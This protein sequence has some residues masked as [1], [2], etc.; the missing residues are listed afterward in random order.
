MA[1]VTGFILLSFFVVAIMY[2][3][4]GVIVFGDFAPRLT[5]L[6]LALSGGRFPSCRLHCLHVAPVC[7]AYLLMI[8]QQ[9]L[10]PA[11]GS[12]PAC[13]VPA[14]GHCAQQKASHS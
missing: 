12:L 5:T 9:C 13:K 11:C 1:P 10:Q 4:L 3:S 14:D 6:F 2:A 7:Q 8:A